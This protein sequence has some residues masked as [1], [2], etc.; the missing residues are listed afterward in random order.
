MDE[1]EIVTLKVRRQYF[2]LYVKL[3]PWEGCCRILT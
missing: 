1:C 3:P 2:E